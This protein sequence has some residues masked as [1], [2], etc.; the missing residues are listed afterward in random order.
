MYYIRLCVSLE[1]LIL[2]F[3]NL[4]SSAF[5]KAFTKFDQHVF[6]VCINH[7]LLC[8][9]DSKGEFL[10]SNQTTKLCSAKTFHLVTHN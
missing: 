3:V 4:G 9:Y 5:L 7:S 2:N 10:L 6:G 8:P 1:R